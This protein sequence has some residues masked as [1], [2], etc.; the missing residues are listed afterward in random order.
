M[1]AEVKAWSRE[2]ALKNSFRRLTDKELKIE[3][4]DAKRFSELLWQEIKRRKTPP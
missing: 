1:K 4:K 2:D 3:Y